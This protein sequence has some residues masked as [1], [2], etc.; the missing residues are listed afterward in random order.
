MRTL[1]T[2]FCGRLLLHIMSLPPIIISGALFLEDL[3]S[4]ALYDPLFFNL[5]QCPSSHPAL[6]SFPLPV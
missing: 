2:S 4:P 3:F 1:F 5:L 6:A